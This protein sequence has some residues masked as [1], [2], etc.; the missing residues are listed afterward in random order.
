MFVRR[1]YKRTEIAYRH[2]KLFQMLVFHEYARRHW[3][4]AAKTIL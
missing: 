3:P 2:P 4:C 1:H